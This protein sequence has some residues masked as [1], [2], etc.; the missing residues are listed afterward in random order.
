MDD[1]AKLSTSDVTMVLDDKGMTLKKNG[2]SIFVS[3]DDL[4]KLM[5][6]LEAVSQQ[7][8]EN[9]EALIRRLFGGEA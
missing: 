3:Y 2:L 1:C 6:Q 4:H 8:Q 7:L 9:N 5:V